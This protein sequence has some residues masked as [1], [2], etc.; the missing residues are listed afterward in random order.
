MR[1]R[2]ASGLPALAVATVMLLC[3]PA[4]A[5]AQWL[6][7]PISSKPEL[8]EADLEA[9]RDIYD[10][11]CWFC[12]GEEGDGEGPIAE[13]LW[14]RPRDFT[15]ASYRLKTTESGELPTDEDLYRT[16]S[17]GIPGTAMPPWSSVLDARQLWQ[18]AGYIK[19]FASDLFD[20]EAFDPYQFVVEIGS[21]PS[22][23][24]D[25]LI[26]RGRL[27][28]EE[29]N[30]WECHGHGGRG[31]GEKA[32]EL[33]DDW[34]I[35]IRAANLKWGWKFKGGASPAEIYLRL[36]S[37]LD[38]SPMPSYSET[39]TNEE[40]WGLAYYISSGL[41][42]SESE[43]RE[44]AVIRGM[45]FG[46]GLPMEPDDP[47]WERVPAISIPLTGQATIAPRWQIPAVTDLQVQAAFDE[48]EIALRLTW[49]DRSPDAAPAD[50][51][52]AAAEGWSA[53]DTYPRLYP[54]GERIRGVFSDAIEVML[55]ARLEDSPALPHFL[56]G[57][58][59][60]R[61]D[62]WRWQA[63]PLQG[64]DPAGRVT[65]LSAAGAERPPEETEAESRLLEGTGVWSEGQ[66]RV[67]IR[68]PLTSG[69]ETD[70]VRLRPGSIVPVAFH[71][72]EGGNGETGLRMALS[73]WYFI[74][75]RE[76]ASGSSY[77]IVLLAALG[78]IGLEYG[79]VRW[80]ASAAARGRLIA[81]G[82]EGRGGRTAPETVSPTG[83]VS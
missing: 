26:E 69:D 4:P 19:A 52:R 27:T 81:F 62:L 80:M 32:P 42:D 72:W 5:T 15:A 43:G 41:D 79:I 53:D 1:T 67:V 57:S 3:A 34:D 82:I 30:C 23:P 28:F 24:V 56:Y 37:G 63:D 9:G 33:M 75:L 38:G 76:P 59:G 65:E 55:P 25:S 73:S 46:D 20:D 10:E 70:E 83:Q 2:P 66:W 12:H 36:V 16:I 13:Y 47:A 35:S 39:L 48:R 50:S 6:D 61:V 21:P 71:V 68:R 64:D 7:L 40:L 60:R 45:R 22:E 11:R 31:D 74:H 51:A 44:T 58:A 17:L 14:P 49:D 18:V 8:D 78:T 77:L 54:G 29:A